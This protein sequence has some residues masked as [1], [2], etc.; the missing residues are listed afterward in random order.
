MNL[1]QMEPMELIDLMRLVPSE[2]A[3]RVRYGKA[4]WVHPNVQL[5][6][7]IGFR[8]VF[9]LWYN[10][11]AMK[12]GGAVSSVRSPGTMDGGGCGW[13]WIGGGPGQKG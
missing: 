5:L 6:P 13:S 7:H 1:R 10:L 8:C 2:S 9:T 12:L 4:L 3:T 11:V